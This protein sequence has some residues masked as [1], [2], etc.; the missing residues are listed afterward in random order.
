M[1]K[2]IALYSLIFIL[3][4]GCTGYRPPR[5]DPALYPSR[6]KAYDLAFAWKTGREG[7]GL[8]VEGFVRNNRYAYLR[9]L[10]LTLELI[11]DN[12][13]KLSEATFFFIPDLIQLDE[14]KPF[15]LK[16]PVPPD[17]V[18]KRLRFQYKYYLLEEGGSGGLYFHTFEAN[19]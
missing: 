15:D 10:E 7:P 17:T 14:V 9:G 19:P 11:D 3:L 13:R 1:P 5:Y 8:T 2:R 18:P 16:L 4:A 6:H 12:G